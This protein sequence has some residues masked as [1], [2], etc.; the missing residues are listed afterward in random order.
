MSSLFVNWLAVFFGMRLFN[1]CT[2]FVVLLLPTA[3]NW[4]LQKT[5]NSC[6]T[7]WWTHTLQLLLLCVF[8]SLR[9]VCVPSRTGWTCDNQKQCIEHTEKQGKLWHFESVRRRQTV[10]SN[11]CVHCSL[12]ANHFTT[13]TS[14]NYNY[15]DRFIQQMLILFRH[16]TASRVFAV[17]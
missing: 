5:T 4:M 13:T 1:K 12:L 16:F 15:R 9:F 17:F 2:Q 6:T 7:T 10:M 3:W 8:F 14:R 11:Y